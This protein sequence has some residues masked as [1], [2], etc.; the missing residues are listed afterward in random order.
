MAED[1]PDVLVVGAGGA[2]AVVAKRL[3]EHGASVVCLEQGDWVD[4]A[5]LPKSHLDWEVRGRRS[6]A[7]NPNVRRWPS[8]YPVASFGENPI[9]VYM[10]NAVGGST[11]GF[12]GN[13]WRFA[14]SDFRM[15]T[16]D[17]VGV[18]WPLNYQQLEPFYDI[19]ERELGVAGL[20]GDPC[21]P[22]RQPTLLP[23]A[24][25]GRPGR[26]LID[27]Y[28]KLGWYW[29]PTEQSIATVPYD[30]RAACDHRG[31]CPY[32]CPRGSLSTTDVTYWPK[33]LKL[34]VSL[35][36]GA[37]VR[38]LTLD[39]RGRAQGAV[40][41]DS[42]GCIQEARA[43]I[44]VLCGGGLGTARLLLLSD[45]PLHPEGL[46]NGS[47]LVGKNL[48]V[49]VQSFAVGRFE[50]PVEG[51][52]GTWGGTVST[53]QFYETDP[54]RDYVRGFIMSGC[55][56]Y[57]PLNL[58]LQLA[59]W[60][61]DHHEAVDRHLNR[62][63]CLYLCGDDLPEEANRVELDWEHLDD[64]G[65]PGV[66][67]F[68]GL[69]DNSRRLGEDMIRHAHQV[70]E[71]AGAESVRDFGLSPIWGWHLMG[72]AR[73]G[74]AAPSSVVDRHQQCHE[75]PNLYIADSS[76]LPTGGGVNPTSTIQALAARCA[77][78][79]WGVRRDWRGSE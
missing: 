32:G 75:V 44:V 59:P 31:Y 79:I 39:S 56:G 8:D 3:A 57:S 41:Y 27:A 62:E 42:E 33:A 74:E 19:N 29:W 36:T 16:L 1:L 46:A 6:W 47:G 49:H 61:A 10:Y 22:P 55:P 48:M 15:R 5:T 51:W 52:H 73:M 4:R 12:A 70:L 65:M 30:G 28:E 43:R 2:G 53:R 18:D 71:A 38:S 24:P 72:T 54:A 11:I 9:D 37:R 26:L 76:S 34:G 60:G 23:P 17:G 64:W 20:V 14:P 7:P 45:S 25:V 63:I 35:I 58:A 21:G 40:Y 50:E 66:K 68:Y 77:E 78:H 67:T 13:Y 69:G